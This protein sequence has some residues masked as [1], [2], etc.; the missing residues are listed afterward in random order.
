MTVKPET[1]DNAEDKLSSGLSMLKPT[2]I[3]TWPKKISCEDILLKISWQQ[4]CWHCQ[5]FFHTALI[6]QYLQQVGGGGGGVHPMG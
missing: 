5:T 6:Y 4:C 1:I 2:I 3:F